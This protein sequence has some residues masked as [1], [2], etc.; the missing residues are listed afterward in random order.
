MMPRGFK[1]RSAQFHGQLSVRP[2]IHPSTHPP[3][4]PTNIFWELTIYQTLALDTEASTI[5]LPIIF[6]F[7]LR[8]VRSFIY[9]L[10]SQVSGPFS[11][12]DLLVPTS[13]NIPITVIAWNG[14]RSL[15]RAWTS[16]W[17]GVSPAWLEFSPFLD[18]AHAHIS[19]S[20]GLPTS[21]LSTKTVKTV[22]TA[23]ATK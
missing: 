14:R 13:V 21:N 3:T 22:F 7:R 6:F 20:G 23:A 19:F 1:M 9:S 2:S 4:R 17:L 18:G 16:T 12:P 10:Y 8:H 5:P 11:F 15:N